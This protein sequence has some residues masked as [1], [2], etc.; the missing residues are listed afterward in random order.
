MILKYLNL[1]FIPGVNVYL[2]VAILSVNIITGADLDISLSSIFKLPFRSLRNIYRCFISFIALNY[3][4]YSASINEIT[5]VVWRLEAQ[6]TGLFPSIK[7]YPPV[8]RD[9]FWITIPL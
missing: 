3:P 5:I 1:A 8:E 7:I 9:S 2:I 4:I 6:D